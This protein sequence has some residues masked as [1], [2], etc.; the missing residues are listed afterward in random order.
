LEH[1]IVTNNGNAPRYI[2]DTAVASL[3]FTASAGVV[4]WQNSRLAI[5]WDVSYLLE[6]AARIA[7]GDVP[8]RDFPFP[9][10]PLTFVIQATIIRLFGRAYWHHVVY[11]ALACG[12]ASALTYFIVRR[13]VARPLAAILCAPLGILGIYCILPIPF[14]DPDCCLAM[15]IIFAVL[16]AVDSDSLIV[17]AFCVVPLLIKQNIGLTFLAAALVLFAFQR[18][19]RAVAGVF[20]GLIASAATVAIIFGI[21]NYLRWTIQFAASRRLPPFSHLLSIYNDSDLWWWIAVV[22]VA[23]FFRHARWLIVV[24]F[25]W[26]E[27]Q[28]FFSDDPT[29]A[30]I[31]F[32]RFWPLFLIV[33]L[34]SA[35]A[36]RRFWIGIVIIAAVHGAFLSQ[37]TWGST[38]G[39]WPLLIILIA[40]V[41][42]SIDQPR[43][44]AVIV[45][46][47]LVHFGAW[48]VWN[49]K[50]LAYA[51]WD[52]GMMHTSSLAPLRGMHVRGEWL[53]QFEELIA[54]AEAHI[55]RNDA[56]LCL[57]GEDLFY[58]T[59]GRRPGVPV[60][61][62]DQTVNPYS[63]AEIA[64][65]P[66]Q[67][68]IV[69]RRLQIRG[70]PYPDLNA[71]LAL[72]RPQLVA[73]LANYDIYRRSAMSRNSS[74]ISGIDARGTV[75][76]SNRARI[77][78]KT[79]R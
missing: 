57:P 18:M 53:P 73:R 29:E 45:S 71:T 24:P 23:L 13:I 26:S 79:P 38:Y 35:A 51:R 58:F 33:A 31:N 5:L 2:T 16:L 15:L 55:G 48:Y 40:I 50:R 54:Y 28:F 74:A 43:V 25:L 17:G 20:I 44:S 47:V 9:Y 6:N 62:F 41:F 7:A 46:V 56:V 1:R 4:L 22:V 39:I 19:W 10:A 11:A 12:S 65:L 75:T 27:Y 32:L 49:N 70:E 30:E 8:Y 59:T 77:G 36:C 78:S 14:Y 3:L 64:A 61:M 60:L 21:G 66:V 76:V 63:P 42:R 69:K 34:W 37:A 67:W 52:E 68:V 72:M